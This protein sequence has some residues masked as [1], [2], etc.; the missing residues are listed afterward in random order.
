MRLID[1]DH[2]RHDLIAL[3]D[4]PWPE[5]GEVAIRRCMSVVDRQDTVGLA[6]QGHW[7]EDKCLDDDPMYLCSVCGEPWVTIAG[8]P[9]DNN[10]HYC[11]NCG[12]I[13][14]GNHNG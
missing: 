10:M 13:M 6:E 3:L 1:A 2:L 8:T 5:I 12:A 7:I 14:E 4:E 9:A 11:P